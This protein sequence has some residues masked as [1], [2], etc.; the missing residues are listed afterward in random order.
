MF[1]NPTP[2]TAL[3]A[4]DLAKSYGA[5]RILDGVD[6]TCSPGL[7]LGIVGENGAGK[8]TLLRLLAGQEPPD[9]GEVKRPNDLLFVPQ[10]PYFRPLATVGDVVREALAPLHSMVTRLEKLAGSLHDEPSAAEEYSEL[11]EQAVLHDAWNADHRAEEAASRLGLDGIDPTRPVAE[12]SGG[13]RSRVALTVL[14]ARR[15][16]CVL[17]DEPTNHLDD[18][19]VDLLEP[20]L[21]DLPGVV[22]AASHDRAFLERVCARVLDLDP[23]HFGTD[24]EGGN[25]FSGGFEA[26]LQ[27][28]KKARSRWEDA[29]TAQ[30]E[31]LA[32][33]RQAAASTARHVAHNRPARDND[34]LTHNF[35]GENVARTVSRRVKDAE[36]RIN[37]I[38]RDQI[39]KPPKP[40]T[41]ARVLT[42]PGRSGLVVQARQ[43]EV[44]G[45][46]TLDRLDVPSG[47]HLLVTGG[48]GSGKSTLL[49]VLAG[50]VKLDA[51][52]AHVAAQDVGFMPQDVVFRNAGRSAQQVFDR[53][54]RSPLKLSELGLLPAR[55]LH[56]PV[57]ELS[58]GQQRRLA[59]AIVVAKQ[60]DLLLLDEPTNHI[61][62]SLAEELFEA[63]QQSPG[64][65]ITA[66]HDRWLRRRWAGTVIALD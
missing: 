3:I 23:S 53:T 50:R 25:T 2:L 22:V 15:P 18:N 49:K 65:I 54:T 14:I 47:E 56:R 27:A 45:R 5:R 10:N 28:K 52:T 16:S 8:S 66:S 59:L 4:R 55:D 58:H 35:K 61:S 33:L 21:L 42:T 63:L 7:P 26:Y 9:A 30:Q 20:F 60:P 32:E 43:L 36:R 37:V 46:L 19:A 24:G 48:N 13:Q 64:T 62:L 51:G 12:L 34:K 17:L 44:R 38:Q 29:F 57:E 1:T 31:T 11:L 39:P 41:F 6:V 40:L